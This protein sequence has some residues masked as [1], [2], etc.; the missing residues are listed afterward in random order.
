MFPSIQK[1]YSDERLLAYVDGEL[2][3]RMADKTARHLAVCWQC[4]A[5]LDEIENQAYAVARAL[6]DDSSLHPLHMAKVKERLIA[7][8]R[9]YE[10]TLASQASVRFRGSAGW[11]WAAAACACMGLLAAVVF[12]RGQTQKHEVLAKSEQVEQ[13]LITHPVRQMLHVQL[14]EVRPSPLKRNGKIEIWSEPKQN[15]FALRWWDAEAGSLR[16]ALWR[17]QDDRQYAY[18]YTSAPGVISHY[19]SPSKFVSLADLSQRGVEIEAIEGQFMNWLENRQ[20]KPITLSQDFAGFVSQEGV[21]LNLERIS[22]AEGARVFRLT[23]R[24]RVGSLTTEITLEMDGT[25]YRPRLLRIAFETPDRA[26]ELSLIS[27][28]VETVPATVLRSSVFTPEVGVTAPP[29]RV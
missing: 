8:Q 17:P 21:E 16:Q 14:S 12:W 27:E 24:R 11:R 9:E 7:A 29:A 4:R 5:R 26:A 20:W 23:A 25:S 6:S 18:R 22:G 19:A 10:R 28:R 13:M 3:G 2:P 1:H 15:H